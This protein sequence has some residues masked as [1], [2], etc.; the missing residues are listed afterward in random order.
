MLMMFQPRHHH[1]SDDRAPGARNRLLAVAGVL[2]W[3]ASQRREMEADKNLR[4]QWWLYPLTLAA[5]FLSHYLAVRYGADAALFPLFYASIV[6]SFFHLWRRQL[7]LHIAGAI[8]TFFSTSPN[9]GILR[10]SR[11]AS[12]GFRSRLVQPELAPPRLGTC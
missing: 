8:H 9:L 7:C 4:K 5:L 2:E 1:Q 11:P 3:T 12:T 10:V 6:G